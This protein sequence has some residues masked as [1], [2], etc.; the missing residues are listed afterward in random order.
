MQLIV[1]ATS[2]T[3]HTGPQSTEQ[4]AA[5]A[6]VEAVELTTSDW[7]AGKFG[8]FKTTVS[9]SPDVGEDAVAGGVAAPDPTAVPDVPDPSEM[10]VKLKP[11]L[12]GNTRTPPAESLFPVFEIVVLTKASAGPDAISGG[13]LR[14]SR[15]VRYTR[16]LAAPPS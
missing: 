10:D 1:E 7:P 3:K 8:K 5:D 15:P 2:C 16:I 14:C 13:T 6:T 4:A 12:R 11:E 9:P